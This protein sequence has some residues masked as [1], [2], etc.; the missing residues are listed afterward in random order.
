[1]KQAA[2]TLF[3]SLIAAAS[4][5]AD[6]TTSTTTNSASPFSSER[7]QAGYALGMLI[8]HN[9][10]QQ[11]VDVDWDVFMQGIKDVQ[12]GGKTLLTQ[13][14]MQETLNDYKKVA[15]A[16]Q[17][18]M[19]EEQAVKNKAEGEKFLTENKNK[20]GV[21]TLPD[22]LQYKIITE[23]KGALPGSND[24]VQVNYRGTLLD[25]TEFDSS[26]K[27]GQPAEFPVNRPIFGNGWTEALQKMKVGSKWQL[28]IPSDLAYG[29]NGTRGILPNSTLIFE[30]ELLSTKPAPAP[31]SSNPLTSDIIA[32]PSATDLKKGKQ[33][34]TLKAEDVQKMQ[35]QLQQTNH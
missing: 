19:R 27:R 34:Y 23:G 3:F 4:L 22:G 17:Q 20:P 13:Q 5:L 33:P 15:M 1:M 31:V 26:Y 32:V 18:Q 28:F 25:G 24:V 12:P 29:E 6:D 21:K 30:V 8:G 16:R 14:Q 10:Q 11:G 35:R 9:L 2:L 7:Q